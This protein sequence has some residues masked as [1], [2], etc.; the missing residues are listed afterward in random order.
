MVN[1]IGAKA[2]YRDNGR[3][4]D[5]DYDGKA[6]T[7]ALVT[8][9]DAYYDFIAANPAVG[10]FLAQGDRVVLCWNGQVYE[11]APDGDPPAPPP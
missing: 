11:T 10:K 1:L 6:K 8:Y 7:S 3:W 2:F 5:A 9:G 4:V